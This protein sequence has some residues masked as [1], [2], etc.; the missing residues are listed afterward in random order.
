[1]IVRMKVPGLFRP[2]ILAT[3]GPFSGERLAPALKNLASRRGSPEIPDHLMRIELVRRGTG[4]D[5]P[6]GGY[7]RSERILGV[8]NVDPGHHARRTTEGVPLTATDEQAPQ[9][10]RTEW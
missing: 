10:R 4:D 5:V 2:H 3:R 7:R 9:L 6:T 8:V 1:M